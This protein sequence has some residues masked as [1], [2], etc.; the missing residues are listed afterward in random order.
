M[1][2][3]LRPLRSILLGAGLALSA[4][5]ATAAPVSFNFQ[6]VV[7]AAGSALNGQTFSGSLRFDDASGSP[8]GS[9]TLF[10]LDQFSF[11]FNGV[12][13][14]LADLDYAD[15]V[16]TGG[17]FAGLDAAGSLFSF[18][19]AMFGA[20]AFFA[21]DLGQGNAGNASFSAEQVVAPVP[22]P[23]SAALLGAGLL[24]LGLRRRKA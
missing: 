7:D 18:L 19:P 16:F 9:E 17:S 20:E 21:F 13:Y 2:Q 24:A 14:T 6:V 23:G 1:H 10:A 8:S 5:A 15:A 4:L 22:E 12:D 3:F 11:S